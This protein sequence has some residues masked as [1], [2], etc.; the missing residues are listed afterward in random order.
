MLRIKITSI[1][2]NKE[3]NKFDNNNDKKNLTLF[4]K[5]IK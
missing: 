3:V 1:R 2:T 4:T 5:I